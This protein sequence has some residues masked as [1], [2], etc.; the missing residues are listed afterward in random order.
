MWTKMSEKM[1]T[2]VSQKYR[3]ASM[4]MMSEY[5]LHYEE[6]MLVVKDI[7]DEKANKI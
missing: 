3:K 5:S 7:L 2:H 4:E 6:Q 1:N